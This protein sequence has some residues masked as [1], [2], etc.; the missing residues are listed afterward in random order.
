MKFK[1]NAA[2][3]LMADFY[4]LSHRKQYPEG[5]QLVYSTWTP[6]ATKIQGVNEV[7]VFGIQGFIKEYLVEFFK[8]N[9]FSRNIADIV[10]DYKRFITATLGDL[11][12]DV[13]HIV[14]LHQ[15]GYLP[16]VVRSLNE[17]EVVPIRTPVLVIYNSD[18][19]F[20]WLTNYIETLMSSILWKPMTSATIALRYKKILNKYAKLT[21][22]STDFVQFQGHD[23]SMRGMDAIE[24]SARSGAG[25]LAAGFVGT[26]TIP[27]IL[28]LE[29]YYNTDVT[30]EL[31]GCSIPAT[32]HSVMCAYED[33]RKSFRRLI[34]E[35]YPSGFLSVVSDTWNL[36]E[37]LTEVLPELKQEVLE[38]DGKLVVR[39][40]SG[41]PVKIVCGDPEG[42]T[43]A[44]RKGVVEL[45]WDTFG[46]TVTNEGYKVLDSHVG[47]IYGDSITLQRC[48][49]ICE[50]LKNKGF[51]SV[52]CVFGIG[53]FTYQYNTRDTFGF[54]L[55]STY[56]RIKDKDV[57]IFKD[58]ITDDGT[59]RSLK[60]CVS[61]TKDTNGFKTQDGLTLHEA[62]N[63]EGNLLKLRFIDGHVLHETSLAEIRQKFA[64]I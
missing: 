38:R 55:K 46:G 10:K 11:D 8:E 34:T 51:A 52:N 33:D 13:S 18:Y 41:D 43:E 20:F 3:M 27:S 56:C 44:E 35:L 4:K 6:R 9:F 60:G 12:P 28:Y 24:A 30:K 17:G 45:L 53:S 22:G 40:D 48:E 49:A 57:P 1:N 39:P 29:E 2:A 26:D 23:F 5:T 31:V 16:L 54:A 61:V 32:E 25:H 64:G 15:L 58:P 21:T 42:K 36:W 59:K 19:R 47:C 63:S 50:G 7:A 14:E 62:T 37:V